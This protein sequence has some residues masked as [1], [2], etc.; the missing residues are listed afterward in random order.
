MLPEGIEWQLGW[1]LQAIHVQIPH[2]VSM[3]SHQ[4]QH[5]KR[6]P[7]HSNVLDSST[8]ALNLSNWDWIYPVWLLVNPT[9][10]S[11][12]ILCQV[13]FFYSS[14]IQQ[15]SLSPAIIFGTGYVMPSGWF[16]GS[17]SG[18]LD[19]VSVDDEDNDDDDDETGAAMMSGAL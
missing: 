14:G 16:S 4:L 19:L 2:Q 3:P 5:E 18:S 6:F 11:C 13:V 1:C 17:S 7:H 15:L 10:S 12:S 9:Q 8:V